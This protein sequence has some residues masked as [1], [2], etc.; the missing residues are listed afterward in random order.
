MQAA[1]SKTSKLQND[2]QC[3]NNLTCVFTYFWTAFIYFLPRERRKLL[4]DDAITIFSQFR[5]RLMIDLVLQAL[6][7]WVGRKAEG[8]G[9]E[10]GS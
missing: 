1:T 4:Q 7:S 6:L 3:S 5:N 9:K 10:N 8:P 2:C